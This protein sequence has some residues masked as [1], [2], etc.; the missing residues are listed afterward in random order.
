M[1]ALSRTVSIDPDVR[2]KARTYLN[3]IPVAIQP[4]PP[5]FVDYVNG[6]NASE[7]QKE[8]VAKSNASISLGSLFGW[9]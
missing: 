2:L 9:L 5:T 8:E 1:R 3:P 4:L 6:T 7:R